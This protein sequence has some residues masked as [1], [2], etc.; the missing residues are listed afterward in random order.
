M[1]DSLGGGGGSGQGAYVVNRASLAQTP[2][3]TP[4]DLP[5]VSAI[6]A[7]PLP[8]SGGV[9]GVIFQAAQTQDTVSTQT[10]LI[11]GT[12]KWLPV[13]YGLN[14]FA[15][16]ITF[17]R[18]R[19]DT[20]ALVMD[21][22]GGEGEIEAVTAA[23]INNAPLRAGCSFTVYRGLT[24]QAVDATVTAALANSLP[25]GT[26]GDPLHGIWHVV[27]SLAAGAYTAQEIKGV[28]L[29]FRGRKIFDPRDASQ[30][31]MTPSTWKYSTNAALIR[32]DFL[33]GGNAIARGVRPRFGRGLVCDYAASVAAF[34]WCDTMVGV[35]PS[36][37]KRG[38]FHGTLLTPQSDAV[39]DEMFK[40]AS[41]CF[42]DLLGD[43]FT[44]IPDM[45]RA[46]VFFIDDNPLGADNIFKWERIVERRSDTVPTVIEGSLP[47]VSK[48]PWGTKKFRVV[49][50]YVLTGQL[51]E[52][53]ENVEM[54]FCRSLAAAQRFAT[55]RLNL[56]TLCGRAWGVSGPPEMLA[57]QRGDLIRA[58][59]KIGLTQKDWVVDGVMDRGGGDVHVKLS[60]YDPA[61]FANSVITE[62]TSTGSG[63]VNCDTYPPI[64]A[65]TATEFAGW[66]PASGGGFACVKRAEL[67]W[68][69]GYYPCLQHY[70]VELSQGGTVL[71]AA[72]VGAAAFLSMPVAV[73]SYT[74]RVRLVSAVAGMAA[75]PWST[76]TATIS[77]APCVPAAPRGVVVTGS[78][79]YQE[80]TLPP[81]QDYESRTILIDAA[82][83][84][85]TH[86][87]IWF[88]GAASN[89]ASATLQ[90]TLV[91]ARTSITYGIDTLAPGG[92]YQWVYQFDGAIT[93]GPLLS[94][95]RPTLP[96]RVWV[97]FLNGALQSA[98]VQV[99]LGKANTAQADLRVG[100]VGY[101][102]GSLRTLDGTVQASA[103]GDTRVFSADSGGSGFTTFTALSGTLTYAYLG[104][105]NQQIDASVFDSYGDPVGGGAAWQA[106]RIYA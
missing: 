84:P 44:L 79:T 72:T 25:T 73:G 20:G 62:P 103:A 8:W 23:E 37:A 58:S 42:V 82:T 6:T 34:N 75:G 5:G 71:E 10:S 76:A 45:P 85:V 64:T 55:Q 41:M 65:M 80:F 67:V 59:H 63:A 66:E 29:T 101:M 98:P 26:Y 92:F 35:Y 95:T 93:L 94:S 24:T 86:T 30:S 16:L 21:V 87:E 68:A 60:E 1:P 2:S 22:T 43:T 100:G 77:N 40:I 88:G 17:A 7:G 81:F 69:V 91:G 27:L 90:A 12:G 83:S 74:L 105:S 61:M 15:G 50:P 102:F 9:S 31:I 11:A 36:Q 70:E 49:N 53:V 56:K 46:P 78:R 104:G 33:T 89:F 96:E 51:P 28:D 52:I 19:T 38:E 57:L 106:S 54:P 39:N 13:S 97:R 14:R 4:R 32:A 18:V 3:P 48:K 99:V 47:D